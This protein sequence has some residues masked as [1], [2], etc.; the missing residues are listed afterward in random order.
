MAAKSETKYSNSK[1]RLL[2][3]KMM[4][5]VMEINSNEPKLTQK[6]ISSN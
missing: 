1:L 3:Q 5:K 2:K 4:S 6:Q